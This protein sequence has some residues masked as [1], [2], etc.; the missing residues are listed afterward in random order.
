M[1]Y[2][3]LPMVSPDVIA[4]S[5]FCSGGA[6][7]FCDLDLAMKVYKRNLEFADFNSVKTKFVFMHA[8]I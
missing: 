8:I 5:F 6:K 1:C 4:G 7:N 2:Q 3:L